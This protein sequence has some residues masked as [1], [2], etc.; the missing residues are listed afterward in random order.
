MSNFEGKL[1]LLCDKPLNQFQ[2]ILCVIDW[3]SNQQPVSCRLIDMTEVLFIFCLCICVYSILED[4]VHSSPDE[5]VSAGLAK[6]ASVAQL[7][8]S[9]GCLHTVIYISLCW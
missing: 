2:Y 7:L 6:I 1:D 3:I 9:T 8:S 5:G 4:F